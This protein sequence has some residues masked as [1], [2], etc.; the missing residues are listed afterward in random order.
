M[1]NDNKL[2]SVI[3]DKPRNIWKKRTVIKQI[4]KEEVFIFYILIQFVTT[5]FIGNT[6]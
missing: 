1:R 6:S 2:F 4:K 3:V 5:H